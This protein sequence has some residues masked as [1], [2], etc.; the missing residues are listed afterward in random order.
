MSNEAENPEM[1]DNQ[2]GAAPEEIVEAAPDP[3]ASA[4]A[5][6]TAEP[7]GE[8]GAPV[9][10]VEPHEPAD[11]GPIEDGLRKFAG[12]TANIEMLMDVSLN[13]TV[14]L[15]RT[16]VSVQD[17]LNLQDGSVVELDRLAGEPV[18]VL[19][20]DRLMA[21]GEVV[22]VDEK[23]GVKITELGSTMGLA[24]Q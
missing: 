6:A 1:M 11:L 19:V 10:D 20:N 23:F 16:N 15:G 24:R 2:E 22:V 9:V 14:E 21:R 18:D 8:A 12:E 4:E 5:A 3:A 7:M 13:V 17:V